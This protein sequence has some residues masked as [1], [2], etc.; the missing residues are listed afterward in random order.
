VQNVFS[1]VRLKKKQK[2]TQQNFTHSFRFEF[3]SDWT[4][5]CVAL[6]SLKSYF[7]AHLY[8]LLLSI[9]VVFGNLLPRILHNRF[10][11]GI[12]ELMLFCAIGFVGLI[13]LFWSLKR[14]LIHSVLVITNKTH[15]EWISNSNY[16]FNCGVKSNLENVFGSQKL[17]FALFPV[18]PKFDMVLYECKKRKKFKK[19]IKKK[20]N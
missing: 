17:Y 5:R 6:F 9:V 13:Q 19:K 3:H 18:P 11:S 4:G 14:I 16:S 7:L 15:F 2:K 12:F 10:F 8:F 20:K 1:E